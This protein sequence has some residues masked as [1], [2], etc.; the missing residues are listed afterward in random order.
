MDFMYVSY[1][2][3]LCIFNACYK[4]NVAYVYVS[5]LCLYVMYVCVCVMFICACAVLT[6]RGVI[7]LRM[8]VMRARYVLL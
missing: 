3:W 4:C 7:M 8:R 6:I 1:L 2:C 5:T